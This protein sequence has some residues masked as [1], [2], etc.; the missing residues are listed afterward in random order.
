MSRGNQVFI[1]GI[2]GGSCSGKTTFSR[3]MREKAGEDHC[4][5]LYQDN[6]YYHVPFEKRKEVNF[7]APEA[8]DFALLLEHLQ[9]LKSGRDI[10]VPSYDFSTY[11]R[12]EQPIEFKARPI[13]ILE[14]LLILTQPLIREMLDYSF[15]IEADTELRF[16]RRSERDVVERGRTKESVYDQFYSQ[17]EPAHQEY[18][19]PSRQFANELVSQEAYLVN[20]DHIISKSLRYFSGLRRQKYSDLSF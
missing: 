17:V 15:F 8:I 10:L 14:G 12:K 4:C 11:A 7:D 9:A 13:V 19:A 20:C 2:A 3:R 18:V 6:Y 1:V 5:I 16:K